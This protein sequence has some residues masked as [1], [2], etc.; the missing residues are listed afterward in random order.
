VHPLS[1]A[2]I[3]RTPARLQPSVRLVVRTVDASVADRLPGLAAE[4]A[5]WVVLSLPA[6]VLTLVTSLGAVSAYVAGDWQDELLARTGE[7]ASVVLTAPT[8]EDFLLPLLE[9][10]LAGAGVGVVS[11]AFLTMLWTASRAMKVILVALALIY[12]RHDHRP[13]WKA[14]IQAFGMALAGLLIGTLLAPLL[15]SGPNIV[16]MVDE[17]IP[18]ADLSGFAAVWSAAYWPTVILVA[19]LAIAL[20]YHVG[21]PG[22]RL[23]WRDELPGA[24]LA[25]GVWLGGSAGLRLYGLWVLDTTSVYGPLSGPI[26]AL[27]WVWLTGFAVLLG[28]E[29]NAQRRVVAVAVELPESDRVWPLTTRPES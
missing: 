7:A 14:R 20:L 18:L 27:L 11:F 6:L 16:A 26:V 25:T 22:P 5:F 23:R 19:T 15:L 1:R 17:W 10:L 29:L 28:A 8:V 12:D 2:V 3:D 13:A 21:V 9:Q 24:A 4:L